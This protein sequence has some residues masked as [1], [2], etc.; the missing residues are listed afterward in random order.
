MKKGILVFLSA[1]LFLLPLTSCAQNKGTG[2]GETG[3][4]SSEAISVETSVYGG[5]ASPADEAQDDG[6]ASPDGWLGCYRHYGDTYKNEDGK[7]GY[8]SLTLVIY[9]EGGKVFGYLS[10]YGRDFDYT[11]FTD[12]MLVTIRG[13]PDKIRIYYEEDFAAAEDRGSM[14]PTYQK[15][16]L[17]FSL[18]KAG[19]RPLTVWGKMALN[20]QAKD[21]E[22]GFGQ[23]DK[24]F[25]VD[26][27]NSADRAHFLRAYGVTEDTAPLYQYYYENGAL[28]VELFYDTAKKAGAGVYYYNG[29]MSGFDV[30][31]YESEVWQD[32]KFT[33]KDD[34]HDASFLPQY[35]EHKIYNKK[36]QLTQY[37]SE[38]ILDSSVSNPT[39]ETI[40]NIEFIYREDGTLKQ[41]KCFYSDRMF[42]TTR[43]SETYYYD[44]DERL[45]YVNAY[46][47][48]GSIEEYY[49]YENGSKTPSYCLTLDHGGSE[50]DLV[51][52]D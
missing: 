27:I 29:S 43:F 32:N 47:T 45:I 8:T 23:W 35:A 7:S 31:K 44:A 6:T 11:Y 24:L 33:V 21:L 26:L 1:L 28:Q 48:H 51:K 10:M 13:T 4:S 38:G 19:D 15:G 25:S 16:D 5:E 17:L 3:I 40:V 30:G 41:K 37:Y 9:Q 50:G 2:A 12:R 36:G 14:F 39:V 52:Y 20:E 42:G 49:I 34:K 46:I 18:Q 22:W